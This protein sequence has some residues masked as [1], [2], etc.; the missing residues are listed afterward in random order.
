MINSFRNK[1][2]E[3]EIAILNFLETG[4]KSRMKKI[5][6]LLLLQLMF[7]LILPAAALPK[8]KD[9]LQKDKDTTDIFAALKFRDIG[10]AIAGGRVSSVVG[11]PGKPYTYYIGAAGGGVFK[12]TDEGYSWKAIFEKYPSSIG[13]IALAPSN[14]NLVWVGTGEAN[15]R[16]DIIDGHGVYFSPDAGASWKFM[17]LKD[18]GQISQIVINPDNPDIVFVA[19]LGHAW[20]P[21]KERGLFKTTDGGKNWKKVLFINDSTGISDV[22][23]EPGNPRVMLAGAWQV[24]RRPWELIDGGEGSGVYQSK[25]GGETWKKLNKGL[26]K[27]L[28][29]R[30]SFAASLSNPEHVYALIESN[31]GTLWDSHNFGDSWS[32]VSNNH[33]L[34]V[35]PFYFSKMAVAPNNDEKVYFL[36]YQISVS[37]DGGKTV[38]SINN[39]IHVD[40]HSIWID[41]D[42]PGRIVEGND[43]GVYQSLDGGK[44]WRYFDNIP[45]EEYYQVAADTNIAYNLGGGL[46]DNNAWYGPSNNLSGS[47]IDGYNWFPVAGGDGEYVVPAPSNPDIIYSESQ[48]GYLNRLNLKTGLR[49]DLRPYFFDVSDKKPSELKYRFNWTTPIAVSYH[50]ANEVYLGANV[51]FKSTDGGNTWKVISPDLT[52]DDKSKEVVSG[53]PINKDVSGAETYCTIMSISISPQD[54]NVIWIGT[55]DGQVQFTTDGGSH[56]TNVTKNIPN[57]PEW[58]R[59]YQLDVSSFSPASCYIIDD[60]HMMDDRTPYV[61]KTDNYGKTWTSITNGLPKDEPCHVIRED[62]NKKGFLVLGNDIGLYFSTDD[63]GNWTKIKSN[64]PTAPVW[65][66]KFIKRNHDIAIAT[67]GRGIF[68][69]DNITPLE[70]FDKKVE[71]SKF[72]YF[73]MQPVYQLYGWWKGDLEQS[74]KYTAPNPPS[75]AVIDYYL[76]SQIKSSKEL[77]KEKQV[78]VLITI[79]NIAGSTIDTLHGT[80]KKGMN[81]VE[82]NL[83]YKSAVQLAEDTTHGKKPNLHNG[84][85]VLPG[86]YRI[87][88][89][90]AGETQSHTVEVL[91]DPKMHYDYEAAKSQ[92]DAEKKIYDDISAM[93]TML[94]RIDAIHEQIANL[95]SSVR[96]VTGMLPDSVAAYQPLASNAKYI[97]S[98]LTSLKDTVLETK[99]QKGVGEDDIHY[100]TRLYDWF[101]N[102]Y[103]SVAGEYDKAPSKMLT[104]QMEELESQLNGFINRYND[105]L[106]NN[107]AQFNSRATSSSLPILFAGK[108][109]SLR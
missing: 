37:N 8:A 62:P 26:P 97:D 74:G 38:K 24:I 10:P 87:S 7:L 109:I 18:A 89:T 76:Q 98:V 50:N 40:H 34:N 58:G 35:R 44:D 39:Q 21:N 28:M 46:Q 91:A 23:F 25:D 78:P 65:D 68:I 103:Y 29:G 53:G 63:G 94:N 3:P 85:V 45:I 106:D 104:D 6:L 54:S 12:T 49:Y 79:S 95:N 100:L 51:L 93:N 13:C 84:P 96:A 105:L 83:H 90:A 27:G 108:K 86:T 31:H 61:Y 102:L 30:I 5:G 107:I 19:V 33:T 56:W 70:G 55:D 32:M 57:L 42:N 71:G 81:R 59:I 43:G 15:I 92:F 52:R 9:N 64:F 41:P 88:I 80:A 4:R 47:N 101:G 60:R 22:V 11:I 20:G 72:T 73:G 67:H 16:N 99:A 48:D 77:K 75:G 36:S 17:G 1:S 82:W 69:L 2:I 66:L 14:P